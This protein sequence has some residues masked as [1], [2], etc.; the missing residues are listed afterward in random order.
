MEK[1]II[2]LI[3]VTIIGMTTCQ[4]LI[5]FRENS[6]LIDLTIA[7]CT[8]IL[9]NFKWGSFF[10]PSDTWLFNDT[11]GFISLSNF[12]F[13]NITL[14]IKNNTNYSISSNGILLTPNSSSMNLVLNFNFTGNTSNASNLTGGGS[15]NVRIYLFR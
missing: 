10:Q 4:D 6:S 3:Y 12:S 5:T 8:Q 7:E 1:R 14:K 13:S 2:L 9:S 11:G 15:L